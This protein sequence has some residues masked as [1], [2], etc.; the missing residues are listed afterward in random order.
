MEIIEIAVSLSSGT[1]AALTG[2][3]RYDELDKVR[4]AFVE[5]CAANTGKFTTWGK[6]WNAF[7]SAGFPGWTKKP[8]A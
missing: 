4:A 6:A 3:R 1:L 7:K 8:V 5:F 2:L